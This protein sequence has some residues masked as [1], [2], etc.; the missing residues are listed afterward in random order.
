MLSAFLDRLRK[1]IDR[2]TQLALRAGAAKASARCTGGHGALA[3]DKLYAKPLGCTDPGTS[4]AFLPRV[5]DGLALPHLRTSSSQNIEVTQEENAPAG[6]NP[7]LGRYE[8]LGEIG[9]GAMGV[10]YRALDPSIGRTVAV[11][12]IRL[13]G[14]GSEEEVRALRLRLIRESQAGGQLSHP[15]IV[16]VF[17]FGEQEDVAFIVME[18]ISGRTLEQGAD[19]GCVDPF[20]P[21][22]AGNSLGLRA[23]LGLRPR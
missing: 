18:F 16:P 2:V 9:R 11:K 3:A 8:I 12:T 5:D 4:C 23:R 15:N 1:S 14:Q 22:Y 21:G 6:S 20:D 10:V 7:K 19:R 13:S 17:D